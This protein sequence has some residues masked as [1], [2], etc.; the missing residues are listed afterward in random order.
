MLSLFL[1]LAPPPQEEAKQ[2]QGIPE[3]FSPRRPEIRNGYTRIWRRP[4][5][6]GGCAPGWTW[7]LN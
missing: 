2:R 7:L 1:F 6:R 4:S 3:Y 5:R